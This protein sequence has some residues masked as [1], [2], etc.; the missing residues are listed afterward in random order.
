MIS[1]KSNNWYQN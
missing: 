1:I